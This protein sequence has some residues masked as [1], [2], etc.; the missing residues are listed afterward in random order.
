[1]DH[2]SFDEDV[3]EMYREEGDLREKL[4]EKRKGGAEKRDPKFRLLSF[5]CGFCVTLTFRQV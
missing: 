2:I 3:M 5:A 4:R 1:M